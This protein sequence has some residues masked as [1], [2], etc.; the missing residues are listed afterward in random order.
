MNA[1]PT[2]LISTSNVLGSPGSS[3]AGLSAILATVGNSVST[4]GL[5]HDVAGWFT[6]GA[7][8]L[9]GIFAIFT[10]GTTL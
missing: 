1:N 7:G 9:S 5:P 6:F 2:A 4:N 8:L 3:F 10:R